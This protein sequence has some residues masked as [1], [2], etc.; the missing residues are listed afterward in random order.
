MPIAGLSKL[1]DFLSLK[2]GLLMV[3]SLVLLLAAILVCLGFSGYKNNLT[4]K[5]ET[6]A[7]N[8]KELQEQR[9]PK[10]ETTL[11]ELKKKID[12][13]K[14]LLKTHTYPSRIFQMLEELA[15]AQIR[16]IDLQADLPKGQL[17][18]K[19][20]AADYGA[21]AKQI[22]I[23]KEDLRISKVDV[24]EVSLDR[25]GQVSSRFLLEIDTAFLR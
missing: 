24:S 25:F 4:N 3:V 10:T 23:F 2:A 11:V 21:L 9:D 8:I 16:F 5:K 18:L 14:I 12:I 1:G 7:N 17:I 13:L 22:I 6:L 19:A 20:Q 15:L